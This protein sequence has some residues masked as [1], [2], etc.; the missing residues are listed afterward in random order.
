MKNVIF[1]YHYIYRIQ[2]QSMHRDF[3]YPNSIGTRTGEGKPLSPQ[4]L[5]NEASVSLF[6][7]KTIEIIITFIVLEIVKLW[8]G[9]IMYSFLSYSLW[10]FS[11]EPEYFPRVGAYSIFLFP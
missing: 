6:F 8:Q 5:M 10:I 11:L 2:I 7:K 9:Y 1:K 3:L 4:Y